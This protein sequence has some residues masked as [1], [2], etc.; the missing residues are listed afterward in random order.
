M[1]KKI[2]QFLLFVFTFGIFNVY[3][4]YVGSHLM[5]QIYN[6]GDVYHFPDGSKGI[7]CYIDPTNPK[8]GWAVALHDVDGAFPMWTY[9]MAGIFLMPFS[10]GKSTD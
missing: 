9:T 1:K 4:S 7:I 2:I 8:K 10:Y 5:A 6:I 3:F